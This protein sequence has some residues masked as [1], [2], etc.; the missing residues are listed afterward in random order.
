MTIKMWLF[1]NHSTDRCNYKY[2]LI[3]IIFTFGQKQEIMYESLDR[4]HGGWY[5]QPWNDKKNRWKI[6][7][8]ITC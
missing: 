6:G 8:V 4:I 3:N 1:G 2:G 5:N 7:N